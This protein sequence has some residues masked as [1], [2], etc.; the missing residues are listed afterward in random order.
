MV[1]ERNI[2][3]PWPAEDIY[4]MKCVYKL[5]LGKIVRDRTSSHTYIDG[6]HPVVL[7]FTDSK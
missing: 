2:K 7:Q 1:K 6:I 4:E 5:L 3:E